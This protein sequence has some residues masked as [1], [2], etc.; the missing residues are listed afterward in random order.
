[1]TGLS[2]WNTAAQ[3]EHLRGIKGQLGAFEPPGKNEIKC[4]IKVDQKLKFIIP[5]GEW[6]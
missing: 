2:T 3:H 4:P 1:M 5:K 6:L